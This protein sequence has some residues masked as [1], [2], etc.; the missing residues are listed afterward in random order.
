ITDTPGGGGNNCPVIT[1]SGGTSRDVRV[2]ETLAFAV[3]ATDSD[4]GTVT[5]QATNLPANAQFSP[6]PATG[7]PT[8]LGSFSFTPATNQATQTFNVSFTAS[9]NQGC[10][11]SLSVP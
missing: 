7:A 10:T 9:D 4:G 1:V 8:A 5:L 11:G 6:N 3:S 2:G